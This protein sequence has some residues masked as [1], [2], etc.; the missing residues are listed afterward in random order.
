M[1]LLWALFTVLAGGAQTLRNAMQ[2]DLI[3]KLGVVG[4]THVRFLF[5]F[6]FA[7]IF[8][9]LMKFGTGDALPHLSAKQL[10]MVLCAALSQIFGTALMLAAMRTKSFVVATAYTKTEPL[11]VALFG[12]VFLG[13]HLGPLMAMAILLATTGVLLT[14]WPKQGA[15]YSW[16]G[17][18]LG[19]GS[20]ALF[21]ISALAFRSAIHALPSGG[22]GIRAS[23][24]L[25]VGLL[26]QTLILTGWLLITD[27]PALG[28]IVRNWR[29][30]L[31]AGFMGAFA[32]QLWFLAFAL[33][34]AAAVRTLALVEVFYARIISG[35][36]LKEVPS[37]REGAGL[38]LIIAGVALLLNA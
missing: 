30:S 21:A 16:Q 5:G 24:V 23:T 8:L 15:D 35:R 36:M 27:R 4:A 3:E 18:A 14:A 7:A 19:L 10:P 1:S 12:L 13:D 37:P 33:A 38:L 26:L 20:A 17:L 32:S 2:R 11:M 28:A 25:A 6:P 22:F 9:L 34:S 29:P 31:L